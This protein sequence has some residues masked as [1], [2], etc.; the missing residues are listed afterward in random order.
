MK[1]ELQ[2]K[3]FDNSCFNAN[4]STVSNRLTPCSL[5]GKTRNVNVHLNSYAHEYFTSLYSSQEIVQIYEDLML[6]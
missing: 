3:K 6:H 1:F 4:S 2:R 5:F